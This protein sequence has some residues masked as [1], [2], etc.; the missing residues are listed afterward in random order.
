MPFW[1]AATLPWCS[2]WGSVRRML[3]HMLWI[4]SSGNYVRGP[5]ADP[6]SRAMQHKDHQHVS[7]GLKANAA[8][9][10]AILA[11]LHLYHII[12]FFTVTG[13]VSMPPL[14]DLLL[15]SSASATPQLPNSLSLKIP[16]AMS[17]S[18][19]AVAHPAPFA[20]LSVP[21]SRVVSLPLFLS[22]ARSS[23]L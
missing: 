8:L 10:L 1:K 13:K 21:L 12:S 11:H 20:G 5:W 23:W 4:L 15:Y 2:V 22:L 7:L 17:Q 18:Q 3:E 6:C 16:S 19:L 14:L 9:H